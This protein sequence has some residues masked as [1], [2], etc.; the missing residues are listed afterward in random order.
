MQANKPMM[1]CL[2]ALFMGSGAAG[3]EDLM[4]VY[5][6]AYASDP[7]LRAARARFESTREGKRQAFAN[8]LPQISGSGSLTK[9]S[10]TF[11]I[12]GMEV[13]D[14]DTDNENLR[15]EVRQTIYDHGNYKQL[16][17]ARAQAEQAQADYDAALQNFV[18]RGAERYFAVLTAEDALAF[19]QAEERAVGRQLEQA[20]QRYEVGLTAITDVHESKARYDNA[21]AR[22]I[23]AENSLSDA[24]E[25]LREL[26]NVYVG[27]LDPVREELPTT[28]PEPNDVDAWVD[29]AVENSPALRSAR[30][31]VDAAHHAVSLARAEFYPTVDATLSYNEFTNNEFVLRDDFQNV[32]G[33]TPAVAEDAQVQVQ[34]RVPLYTGGRT[35]SRVRQAVA[36][37]EAAQQTYEEQ[38]RA[39]IRDTRNAFRGTQASILEV[40]AREQAVVSARSALEATEAG[41]EV[42][43]RTIVDVLLS[44]QQ[45]FQAQRDHSQAR[46][47]YILN[48][49]R[50]EEAAGTLLR[51]DI[52][53]VN[54]LLVEA[55][56]GSG[57][58][59]G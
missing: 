49:L 12:G 23:V 59:E 15:F 52:A 58:D 11:S 28:V 45:L 33:T 55:T 42:G 54:Q 16:D 46:H 6:L 9:G 10:S 50:L 43:T 57:E 3:A 18:L 4:D 38:R 51:E 35:S 37:L 36:D 8:F 44:Q 27:Q 53:E 5:E 7:A 26:T 48:R 14:T 40:E 20:E 24:K 32:I 17:Q 25:A 30:L 13:S 29:I 19:A 34:L 47:D 2:A 41:F 22:V 1:A 21:R 31:A 56:A 39:V